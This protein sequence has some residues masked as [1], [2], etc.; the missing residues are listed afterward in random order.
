MKWPLTEQT[1]VRSAQDMMNE[2][3]RSLPSKDERTQEKAHGASESHPERE[4]PSL[5]RQDLLG[6]DGREKRDGPLSDESCLYR[7]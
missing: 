7:S 1:G 4:G 2:M 6:Q 5:N 3:I